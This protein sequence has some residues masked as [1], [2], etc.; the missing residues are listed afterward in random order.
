MTVD[1]GEYGEPCRKLMENE[2]GTRKE[3]EREEDKISPNGYVGRYIDR[4]TSIST[5][6]NQDMYRMLCR[7]QI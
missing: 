5:S 1:W 2:E 6:A 4:Y 7:S 3:D